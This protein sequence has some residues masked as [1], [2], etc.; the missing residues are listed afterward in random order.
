M[1]WTWFL[2]DD[3]LAHFL[4]NPVSC[5]SKFSWSLHFA[6]LIRLT[7]LESNYEMTTDIAE[8]RQSRLWLEDRLRGWRR[9]LYRCLQR[10]LLAW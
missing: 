7:P 1:P 3:P 9:V 10:K 5:I 4:Y 8:Y 2:W 6:P